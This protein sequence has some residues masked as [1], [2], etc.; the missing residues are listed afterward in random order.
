MGVAGVR[1]R[2]RGELARGCAAGA[3]SVT[4]TLEP[5]GSRMSDCVAAYP[6]ALTVSSTGV[7]GMSPA[8]LTRCVGTTHRASPLPSVVGSVC[9]SPLMSRSAMRAPETGWPVAVRASTRTGESKRSVAPPARSSRTSV[10]STSTRSLLDGIR[11]RAATRRQ[12][13]KATASTRLS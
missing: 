9:D 8:A 5:T 3:S 1:R 12:W 2:R 10:R 4:V 6:S 7:R 11:E 13:S